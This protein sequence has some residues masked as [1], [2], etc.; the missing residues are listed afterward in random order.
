LNY[1]AIKSVLTPNLQNNTN[2]E[3]KKKLK[4]SLVGDLWRE[5]K[6]LPDLLYNSYQNY[7]FQTR[8]NSPSA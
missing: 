7:S 5:S 4:N 1:L 8:R 3:Y 2:Q 6:Q